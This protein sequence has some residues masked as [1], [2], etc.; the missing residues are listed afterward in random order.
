MEFTVIG[1]FDNATEA[2]Q[3]V[4]QLAD[5]GFTRNNIDLS[6]QTG[7]YTTDEFAPDRQ[8]TTSGTRTDDAKEAG[9]SIGDFFGS[10]FGSDHDETD[11]YTRVADRGSVVTVHVQTKDGAEQA[12]DI[13]DENG[14]VDV[15]ERATQNPT[16]MT[17]TATTDG[18]QTVQIIEEHLQVGKRTVETGGVRLRS[19]IVEKPVEET[20][21]LRRERVSVQRN[22][23]DRLA[24]AADLEAFQEGEITMTEHGEVAVVSKESRVV[25]EV[26]IGKEV[27]ERDEVIRD[28]VRK[29]DVDVEQLNST[30][31]TVRTDQTDLDSDQEVTYATK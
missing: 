7:E 11:K 21:R 14:A 23:V 28:T 13:L 6:V 19:R 4:D 5:A 12:A 20:L 26:S 27:G 8:A 17:G 1:V 25:E 29:T 15:N 9:S 24:T 2:K 18:A 3:A 16:G 10:L 22:P 30:N 31:E